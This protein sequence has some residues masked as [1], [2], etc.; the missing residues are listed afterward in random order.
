L[1]LMVDDRYSRGWRLCWLM[2]LCLIVRRVDDGRRQRSSSLI[3]LDEVDDIEI[4]W[5]R[6]RSLVDVPQSFGLGSSAQKASLYAM[7][8]SQ[9]SVWRLFI[10]FSGRCHGG[11]GGWGWV[12]FRQDTSFS[13]GRI[14][15][16]LPVVLFVQIC[17]THIIVSCGDHMCNLCNKI[18]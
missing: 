12:T 17:V 16:F 5:A 6:G 18:V 8:L 2:W 15:Y 9:I 14:D 4:W 7:V 13:K 10:S 1:C 3:A 11:D